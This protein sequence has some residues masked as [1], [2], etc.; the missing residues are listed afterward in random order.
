MD[1]NLV[2]KGDLS[3]WGKVHFQGQKFSF[4]LKK[5]KEGIK[6]IMKTTVFKALNIKPQSTLMPERH[7][8][9]VVR[10]NVAPVCNA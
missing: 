10:V 9:N 5:L 3:F 8:T 4:S 6:Y 1:W 2:C 7:K